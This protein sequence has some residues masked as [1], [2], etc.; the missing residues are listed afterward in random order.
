MS[1]ARTLVLG[2]DDVAG[3]LARYAPGGAE[4]VIAR[5]DAY[6]GLAELSRRRWPAVVLSAGGTELPGLSRAARRLQGD[7]RLI[8]LCDPADEPAARSLRGDVLDDYFICPP[9]SADWRRIALAASEPK[10][11]RPAHGDGLTCEEVSRLI[12]AARSLASLEEAVAELVAHRLGVAAR[13]V[14]ADDLPE[15]A[16]PLLLTME[17]TARAM[18]APW[19]G[20]GDRTGD[21]LLGDLRSCMPALVS[22]AERTESLHRL[23]VTDHLTGAYNRRYFYHLTDRILA[24]AEGRGYRVT[25]LL[26]DVD[27]LKQYNDTYGHAAG[28][29]ILRE[30]AAMMREITRSQDIVARIGGDEFAVLFW[31][32]DPPRDPGSEPLDSAYDLADRFRRAVAGMEFPSLGPDAAGVLSISGGLANYP[33]DGASCR[34]LLR[35]ADRALDQAKRAGKNGIRIIGT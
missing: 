12:D 29:E 14:D 5:G 34:E 13:W 28:D 18:V 27:D 30:T 3:E 16:E 22:T 23:A 11:P 15:D 21:P 19:S 2:G 31:D 8:A 1:R 17:D 32:S 4:G 26:Y 10:P 20:S 25:L 24:Q 7:A 33:K 9:N 35:S 6:E